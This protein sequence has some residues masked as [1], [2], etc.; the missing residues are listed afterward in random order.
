MP[1]ARK[2]GF[3]DYDLLI[4]REHRNHF[5]SI[6]TLIEH[7]FKDQVIHV[8]YYPFAIKSWNLNTFCIFSRRVNLFIV[9]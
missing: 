2:L 1:K 9:L 4:S 8:K 3:N 7:T 5:Q 6:K